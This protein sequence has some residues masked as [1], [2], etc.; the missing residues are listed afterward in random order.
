[1]KHHNILAIFG[2]C[3]DDNA[4]GVDVKIFKM[5]LFILPCTYVIKKI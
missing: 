5:E 3:I 1:M 2:H 4:F